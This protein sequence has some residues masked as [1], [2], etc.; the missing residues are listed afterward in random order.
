MHTPTPDREWVRQLCARGTGI[1]ADGVMLARRSDRAALA[2][3]LMNSDGSVPEM[4]GN[5]LRCLVKY[6]VE[7]L[8]LAD[9][10]L[11]V[12]TGAGVLSCRWQRDEA[13]HVAHVEVAMGT[14]TFER[15]AVPMTGSGESV[16]IEIPVGDRAL[17]ATG[18]GTGNPH[19][20]I[21]GDSSVETA[22]ALGP[23]L[24]T[25]PMWPEGTNVEF[26]S[27]ESATHLR[28]TVWERG[29]GLTRA[30]GTGATAAAAAAVRLGHCPSDTPIRVSLP[31][32]DLS[33][34]IAADLSQAW[35][36]G[37]ATEVYRGRTS[38]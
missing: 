22:R 16:A 10:P 12:E 3:E 37:P 28:V 6:A 31:G 34:R 5:G 8:G 13:G 7:E 9:N 36:Q 14:P 38:V 29:C 20:V 4:C 24:T 15:S 19:M 35:M 23:A 21:F 33:I 11:S 18:V 25:H 27:I 1:G 26:T 17:T 2:M 30:C 32:G